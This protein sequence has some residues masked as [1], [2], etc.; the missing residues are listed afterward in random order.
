M[1]SR[2][3]ISDTCIRTIFTRFDH[4]LHLGEIGAL[5]TC[6]RVTARPLHFYPTKSTSFVPLCARA[7]TFGP[8]PWS[9]GGRRADAFR[10]SS[11]ESPLSR[12]LARCLPGRS[13]SAWLHSALVGGGS[14]QIDLRHA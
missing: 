8:P 10:M 9:G 6:M 12:S 14:P 7:P 11:L 3:E 5:P 2:G 4:A 13:D 1:S